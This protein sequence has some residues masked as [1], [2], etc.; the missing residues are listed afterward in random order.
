L[1]AVLPDFTWEDLDWWHTAQRE[2]T[3]TYALTQKALPHEQRWYRAFD[4]T[5]FKDVK[6]VILGQDP[7][8]TPG[9]ANGLAF[10]TNP[11]VV[12]LPPSL[13]NIFKEYSSDLGFRTPRSGDLTA[14]AERGCLLLNT[15]LTVE[16]HKP[17]SHKDIGWDV[18]IKEVLTKLNEETKHSVFILWGRH[19]QEYHPLI[20]AKRHLVIRSAHPSPFSA[21]Q[22]FFGSRP[23]TRTNTY[24]AAHGRG[25]IDWRLS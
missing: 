14:W 21:R 12:L 3:E 1:E 22:G 6:C 15:A 8:H 2:E 19:A 10:S 24:L 16:P 23:F 18:L 4:L 25:E 5:P 13:R 11:D 20:H 7:Y 17:A 9:V